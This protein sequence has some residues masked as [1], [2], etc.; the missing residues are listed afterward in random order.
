VI[1]TFKV[2]SKVLDRTDEDAQ[3]CFYCKLISKPGPL[4][5]PQNRVLILEPAC[6]KED[7][8]EFAV[9]RSPEVAGVHSP[10]RT[11]LIILRNFV[12]F[13]ELFLCTILSTEACTGIVLPVIMVIPGSND[14]LL[15]HEPLEA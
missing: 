9:A 1:P 14:R 12:E 15:L 8:L 3:I 13:Q 5:L 2:I 10:V 6:I 11:T 4:L 7:E